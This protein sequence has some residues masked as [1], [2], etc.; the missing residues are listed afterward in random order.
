MK[1]YSSV[2]LPKAGLLAGICFIALGTW[3]AA[4]EKAASDAI[5]LS[6]ENTIRIS[7]GVNDFNGNRAASQT[8][9]QQPRT[10]FGGIEALT[11]VNELSKVTTLQ[12]D[13]RVLPG[14]EDYLAQ[15]RLT[16]SKV[17]AMEAGYK[18]FRTFYD[19]AG[20]FFP[21]NNAW[22]PIY[23]RALYVDR[24]KFFANATVALPGAPVFTL[25]YT[26]ET[27]TGRKDSTIWGDTDL[28]GVPIYS[29]GAL[30]PIS[31]NR[32]IIPAYL[33]LNERHEVLQ[34][35]VKHTVGK[36]TLSLTVIGDRVNNL[37]RRSVDRYPGELKPFPA[38]PAN[39]P[40]LVPPLLANNENK[41]FDQQGVSRNGLT[42]LGRIE[43]PLNDKVSVYATASHHQSDGDTTGSRLINAKLQTLAGLTNEIGAFTPGGRPPYSY[44]STGTF[45]LN[46]LTGVVG[47]ETRFLKELRIAAAYK[48]EDYSRRGL[49]SAAYV[50]TMVN[51]T[52]G[53]ITPVPLIAP[54]SSKLDEKIWTPELDVRYTGIK[55]LALYGTWD[56]R[57]APGDERLSYVSIT[58]A[59]GGPVVLAPAQITL[60]K[61][62]EKHTNFKV[63]ASWTVLPQVTLRGEF[64]SRDHENNFNGY[65]T[66][67]GSYYVLNYDIYGA[68]LTAIVKVSPTLS[69]STRYVQ[70]R[71]KAQIA[72]DGYITGD[73]NDSK[74]H[75]I[76]ETI[77]WTPSRGFYMQ[78]NINVVFDKTSTAYPRAGGSANDVLHNADNN[79]WN[80]NIVAGFV[81]DKLTDAEL[82]A[83]YY[84]ANNYNPA[85]AVA[86]DPYGAGAREYGVFAG[87]KHKFSDKLLG[88][89]KVGYLDRR[90]DTS[91]GNSNFRGPLAYVALERAF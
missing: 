72:E 9:T 65:G 47:V 66:S 39:P 40:T 60:E 1:A 80:G 78:T 82:Q 71:G 67:L 51:Q 54:N 31:A 48:G 86:T 43:T 36:T 53:V 14:A 61:L 28:T 64:F 29:L 76:G 34:A 23:P 81:V 68:R 25:Q 33:Q 19:G 10:G 57:T 91:G 70:Q 42:F 15:F 63:G 37:N 44:N 87:L 6:D 2:L 35:S 45:D 3:A 49:S 18:R 8:R 27:R 59:T 13:G 83:T 22:L 24:G 16:K 79:Y 55:N 90:N 52:T 69:F 32:K 30:N 77:N 46:I 26:N 84:R 7:G 85:L 75:H 21:L 38:I 56:Y 58:P 50:S 11:Y 41:G 20:G 73:S 17:G 4:A 62:D 5:A 88:Q 89:A 12:I 74:R